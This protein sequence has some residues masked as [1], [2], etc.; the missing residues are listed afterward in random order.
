M[1]IPA[2]N[3]DDKSAMIDLAVANQPTLRMA[4]A[5]CSIRAGDTGRARAIM[6]ELSKRLEN[7]LEGAL[8]RPR[9]QAWLRQNAAPASK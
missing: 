3:G 4:L 2:R 9:A 7:N 8:T 5:L 6:E 1:V